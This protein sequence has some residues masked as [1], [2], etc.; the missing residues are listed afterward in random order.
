VDFP[1]QHEEVSRRI[2]LLGRVYFQYLGLPFEKLHEFRNVANQVF[3]TTQTADYLLA[4]L[5]SLY[6]ISQQSLVE[7]SYGF[8]F[9]Q[10]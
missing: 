7:V 6:E 5:N 1:G 9:A 3:E 8:N 10:E 2:D 4:D